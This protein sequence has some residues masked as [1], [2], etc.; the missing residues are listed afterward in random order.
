MSTSS[1]TNAKS[2]LVS[3]CSALVAGVDALPDASFVLG[4][5]TLT[6]AQVLAPLVAYGAATQQSAA[7]ETAW[8]L[9]LQQE[10][11]AGGAARAMVDVLKPYLQ[12]RLGK[13]N[14]QLKTQFGIPPVKAAQ[15]S[16]ETKARAA[17]KAKATRELLGT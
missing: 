15:P 16:A 10:H 9:S 17:A 1:K 2:V 13:S 3:L 5:Q 12:G 14:P 8:H 6:K 11:V 4:T 7:D